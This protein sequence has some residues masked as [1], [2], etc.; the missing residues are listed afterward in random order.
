MAATTAV[1]D[2][3]DNP[4]EHPDEGSVAPQTFGSKGGVIGRPISSKEAKQIRQRARRKRAKLSEEE[5]ALLYGKPIEEWDLEELARGRARAS[6][7]TFKGKTPPYID[8][9]VHEQIV[10]RFEEIVRTEMNAHTVDALTIIGK[11]LNDQEIDEKGKPRTAAGTKLDAAKFLIEHVIG[12][13]KQ[14][15]EVDIS[16]KLQGILGVAIVNPSVGGAPPR[17]NPGFI[18]APS[19]EEDDDDDDDRHDG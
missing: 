11:I 5:M 9:R 19:W 17:L 7:G 6:D 18:E 15:T 4:Y 13:P 10:R 2:F 8:R 3:T 1:I 14:R 12:K 16:A